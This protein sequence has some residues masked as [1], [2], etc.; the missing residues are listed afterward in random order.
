MRFAELWNAHP[1]DNHPCLDELGEPAF[2]NQCAIRMGVA[3]AEAGFDMEGF[4]GHTCW[5][6]HGGSHVLRAEELARWL[7]DAPGPWNSAETY[8]GITSDFLAERQ[9]IV[10]CRNFWGTGNQGDHI[11]LWNGSGM[12]HGS[13]DYIDRSEEVVFWEVP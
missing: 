12:R 9:G 1:G 3:L 10:F 5:H 4:D 13:P 11:D 6:G 2:E 7:A 8:Q